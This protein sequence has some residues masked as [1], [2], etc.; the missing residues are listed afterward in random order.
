M[1]ERFG[2]SRRDEVHPAGRA[3][4]GM[5]VALAMAM[6]LAPF[7][8]E[9]GQV[10]LAICLI[11]AAI[12]GFCFAFERV[13]LWGALLWSLATAVAGVR[14]IF[15]DLYDQPGLIDV[16]LAAAS[17]QAAAL[18]W[19]TAPV[20]VAS[21]RARLPA[22]ASLVG[23]AVVILLILSPLTVENTGDSTLLAMMDLLALPLAVLARRLAVAERRPSA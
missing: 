22:L 13:L 6:L 8:G 3:S 4:L 11:G 18:L 12:A 2:R 20:W 19:L 23:A 10:L 5:I 1:I 9:K 7:I 17:V 14:V 21:W 15:F 16:F